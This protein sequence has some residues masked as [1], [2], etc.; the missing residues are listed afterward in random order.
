MQKGAMEEIKLY[1]TQVV[2]RVFFFA[3]SLIQNH[4]MKLNLGTD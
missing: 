2:G 3:S 1:I 4:P